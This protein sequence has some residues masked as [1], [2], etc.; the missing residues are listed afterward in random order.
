MAKTKSE[1]IGVI[2]FANEEISFNFT[3]RF[4]IVFVLPLSDQNKLSYAL[5]PCNAFNSIGPYI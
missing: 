1:K 4:S 5:F 2:S 3:K